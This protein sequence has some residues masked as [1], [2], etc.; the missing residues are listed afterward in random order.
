[1]RTLAFVIFV[2][3]TSSLQA[4]E[5]SAAAAPAGLT[6]IVFSG[7]WIGLL[8]ILALLGLSLTAAY[9]V[10]EQLLSLRRTQMIPD[11]LARQLR[12]CVEQGQLKQMQQLCQQSPS[13]LSSVTLGGIAEA[14]GGWEEIQ[15]GLEETLAEQAARLFRRVEYLSVIGNIAPMVGLLGTV[16]GMIFAFQQV[17]VTQGGASAGQLAEGIYQALVTTVGGLLIAIPSLAAFAVFRNRIDQ[18]VAETAHT[19]QHVWRPLKRRPPRSAPIRT[20]RPPKPG[21]QDE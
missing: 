8:I 13:L 14:E 16:V 3:A 1:M 7:G 9:L 17:A 21:K 19:L 10:F 2:F 11:E 12:Q 5:T 6:E 18:L 20:V 4:Q 15:T